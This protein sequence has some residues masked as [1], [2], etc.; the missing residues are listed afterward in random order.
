[1]PEF[2]TWTPHEAGQGYDGQ[3]RPWMRSAWSASDPCPEC[4]HSP[5][6]HI[7]VEHCPVCELVYQATPQF[8]RQEVRRQGYPPPINSG[9]RRP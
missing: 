1:M 9:S 3:G 5:L 6:V 8:R 7:G 4:G 2:C